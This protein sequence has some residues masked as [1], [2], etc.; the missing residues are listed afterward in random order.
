M[1][2]CVPGARKNMSSAW[3]SVAGAPSNV[4]V[5]V[6][7][8]DP[9]SVAEKWIVLRSSVSNTVPSG[10]AVI[11]GGVVSRTYASCAPVAGNALHVSLPLES[12]NHVPSP[13]AAGTE[14]APPL[15]MAANAG[16]TA[17]SL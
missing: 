8:P 3:P 17:P 1:I 13:P 10:V 11:T 16:A 2:V 12:T 4:A 6:S 9:A 15:V 14:R 7:T 5:T